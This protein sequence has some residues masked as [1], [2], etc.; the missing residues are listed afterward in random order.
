MLHN[1]G[2]MLRPEVRQDAMVVRQRHPDWTGTPSCRSRAFVLAGDDGKA[3]RRGHAR[4]A[5]PGAFGHSGAKGQIAWADP[6]TGVSFA[7]LTNGMD[8]N[9]LAALRRSTALSTKAL[10]CAPT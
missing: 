8:R 2:D 5:S 3:G 10:D 7:Y 1:S 6:A 9:E 4:N